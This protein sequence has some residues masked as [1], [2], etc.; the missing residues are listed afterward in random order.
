MATE[1]SLR[2]F[3]TYRSFNINV[4]ELIE[5]IKIVNGKMKSEY[6]ANCN[7]WKLNK[8]VRFA[9]LYISINKF[10]EPKTKTL[11][12]RCIYIQHVLTPASV[13]QYLVMLAYW[14]VYSGLT[15]IFINQ[16]DVIVRTLGSGVVRACDLQLHAR[17]P[18]R[19]CNFRPF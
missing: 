11:W 17:E 4:Y 9:K 5:I 1:L 19:W 16:S 15:K 12:S 18:S 8:N 3:I 6:T 2:Y 10:T 7:F 13:N 14:K